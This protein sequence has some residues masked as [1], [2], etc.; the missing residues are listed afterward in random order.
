[1]LAIPLVHFDTGHIINMVHW[2]RGKTRQTDSRLVAYAAISR[3]VTGGRVQLLFNPSC[4]LEWV[5]GAEDPRQWQELSE[6]FE[7][8]PLVKELEQTV[9]YLVELIEETR[10]HFPALSLPKVPLVR[11]VAEITPELIA[12]AQHHLEMEWAR[13][14][15]PLKSPGSRAGVKLSVDRSAEF[16]DRNR[17]IIMERVEGWRAAILATRKGFRCHGAKNMTQ[18]AKMEWANRAQRL[19]GLLTASDPGVDQRRLGE[20]IDFERLPACSL[21]LNALWRYAKAM[22]EQGPEDNDVDDWL[23][24]PAIAYAH[25]SLVER[26]LANHLVTGTPSIRSRLFSDPVEF[27]SALGLDTEIR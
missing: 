20:L 1:M 12:L 26:R 10:R 15:K 6:F 27:A 4:C 19:S 23:Q 16:A 22:S 13:D 18:A 7:T 5:E 8:A 11:H 21:Y 17:K 14:L 25:Y 3:A 24:V 9:V 2:R